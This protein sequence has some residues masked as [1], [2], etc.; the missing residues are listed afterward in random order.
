MTA[1][2]QNRSLTAPAEFGHYHSVN[3]TA[4]TRSGSELPRSCSIHGELMNQQQ[5]VAQAWQ[6]FLVTADVAGSVI[7]MEDVPADKVSKYSWY[8]LSAPDTGGEPKVVRNLAF[9]WGPEQ[10]ASLVNAALDHAAS[11]KESLTAFVASY[12][13]EAAP[14][15]RVE[16]QYGKSRFAVNFPYV[17]TDRKVEFVPTLKDAQ[18]LVARAATEWASHAVRKKFLGMF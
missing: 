11:A 5:F 16:A 10:Q 7:E 1:S 6:L 2:G 8:M 15:I 18:S 14:V 12:G 13:D 3:H 9:G 17:L 4:D